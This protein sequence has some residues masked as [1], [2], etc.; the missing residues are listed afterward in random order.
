MVRCENDHLTVLKHSFESQIDVSALVK[1]LIE[2]KIGV[3]L[4]PGVTVGSDPGVGR[5]RG[6]QLGLG[7]HP[8]VQ[9]ELFQR[10]QGDHLG[11][12]D[13]CLSVGL[14]P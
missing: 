5:R 8:G 9:D 2:V 1:G 12:G 11:P 14:G 13:H 10:L 7:A 6:H 4:L 3:K